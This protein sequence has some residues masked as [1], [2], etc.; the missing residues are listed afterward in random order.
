MSVTL[1]IYSDTFGGAGYDGTISPNNS[2]PEFSTSGNVGAWTA[3]SND[4]WITLVNF[5]GG[6]LSGT[7]DASFSIIVD[8]SGSTLQRTGSC[9]FFGDSTLTFTVTQRGQTQVTFSPNPLN[10]DA[11]MQ[12]QSVSV[13]VTFGQNSQDNVF[14]VPPQPGTSPWLHE[15]SPATSTQSEISNLEGAQLTGSVTLVL[16]I[17]A[18]TSGIARTS[19]VQIG[20]Q[21]PPNPQRGR[22]VGSLTS[23]L[24]VHQ[25][26]TVTSTAT[27][28]TSDTFRGILAF[29]WQDSGAVKAAIHR[30]IVGQIGAGT[31]G[32][33]STQTIESSNG[34]GVGLA[35]L[36]N[37]RLYLDYALSG[38]P[39]FR[40]N[41]HIGGGPVGNWSSAAS[42]SPSVNGL[43]GA[44]RAQGQAYRFRFNGTTIEFSQCRDAAG[45]VWTSPVTVVTGTSGQY[46]GACWIGNGYGCLYNSGGSIYFLSTSDP[47]TWPSPVSAVSGLTYTTV[48]LARSR[49]GVLLSL[50]WDQAGQHIYPARSRDM[51]QTWTQD[52][53]A[54]S[55]LGTVSSP[56]ALVAIEA[57]FLVVYLSSGAPAFLLSQDGGV[58]WS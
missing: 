32:W 48:A 50:Q 24:V 39:K 44:G 21:D 36:P 27:Q 45:A 53:T 41:D 23:S 33:D 18:N 34:A 38:T 52:G 37:G 22:D 16:S 51:G 1:S 12:T 43:F 56:P 9:T 42:P 10:V 20:E 26:N 5:F 58:T 31:T 30:G 25:S 46:A 28:P 2:V 14:L 8:D 11:S 55:A 49:A 4:A 19:Q 6:G 57:F 40:T 29:A 35:Y 7:G 17:D 15:T 3:V 54:I 47:D 13:T